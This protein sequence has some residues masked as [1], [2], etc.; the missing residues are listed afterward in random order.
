MPTY[1]VA[2]ISRATRARTQVQRT[3]GRVSGTIRGI[4]Q[5]MGALRVD[6][7]QPVAA[8]ACLTVG[9]LVI[10]VVRTLILGEKTLLLKY[11]HSGLIC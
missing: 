11:S 3:R 6:L 1:L 2:I 8:K 5:Q 4:A 7:E 9:V 10:V